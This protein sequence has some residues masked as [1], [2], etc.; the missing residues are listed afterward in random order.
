MVFRD[1][2]DGSEQ[3]AEKLGAYKGS[4]DALILAVPRGG[5]QVGNILAKELDLPLDIII[6]KKIPHHGNPEFAIGGVGINGHIVNE[7]LVKKEGLTKAYIYQ[8]IRDLTDSIKDKYRKYRGD[9]KP[10][11]LKDKIVILT[12]DGIATGYTL[13][14]AVDLIRKE[15]P[16]K[17]VLAIPVAAVDSLGQFRGK[18]DEIICVDEPFS[19]LAVSQFYESFPEVNDEEAIKLLQEK[20][21]R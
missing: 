18:V 21:K 2:F 14:A 17:I 8:E 9:K 10:P 1:R 11:E 12:D 7:E 15:S 16:K 5:L 6:V 20:W 3:L 19:F 13:L 4:K